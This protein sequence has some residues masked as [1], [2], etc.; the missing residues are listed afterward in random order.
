LT[1]PGAV[2]AGC[3]AGV[4]TVRGSRAGGAGAAG[5]TARAPA[6]HW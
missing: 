6:D 4:R 3:G 5:R 1:K 2:P